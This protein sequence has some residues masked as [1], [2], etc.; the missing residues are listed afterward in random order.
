MVR[1][2]LETELPGPVEHIFDTIADLRGYDRWL[3]SSSAFKGTTE[4]S[5]GPLAVGT[6]YVETAPNGV[7]RG[8]VVE[9]DPPTQVT[10][11]QPMTM[12][13]SLLG[14]IDIHVGYTLTPTETGVRVSRLTTV[15]LG[16]PLRLL[17]PVVLRQF[18]REGR[19][20]MAALEK[21]V[22]ER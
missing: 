16:W 18:R 19:R 22:R 20:T 10:F 2:F 9:F 13:P 17:Q 15:E 4:I 21:F 1:I 8:T 14:V 6:T 5:P 11:H 3:S 12:K 7:R